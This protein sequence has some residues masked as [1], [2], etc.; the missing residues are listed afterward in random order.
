M[1]L[2][3]LSPDGKLVEMV[4][5]PQQTHPFFLGCQFHPEFRS[6]PTAPHPLFSAFIGAAIDAAARGVDPERAVAA[7]ES[8]Q[9]GSPLRRVGMDS[10]HRDAAGRRF[11]RSRPVRKP[12]AFD[13]RFARSWLW[14][15]AH[16][17]YG[18]SCVA[19][20]AR[21]EP[22]HATSPWPSTCAKSCG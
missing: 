9:R 22:D 2:S 10:E 14:P 6:R 7:A 8:S 12:G 4:E 1:V 17:C 20:V 3:G 18:S 19:S 15:D 5:L 13:S 21:S 16:V 11:G